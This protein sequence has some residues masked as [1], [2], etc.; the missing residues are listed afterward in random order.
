MKLTVN[1]EP[2]AKESVEREYQRLLKALGPRIEPGELDRISPKLQRQAL[3]HAIGRV[4]LLGEARR[5][6]IRVA[7]EEIDRALAEVIRACGGEA[8]FQTHLAKLNLSPTDLRRQI[9]EA[10]QTERLIEE[11]TKDCPQPEEEEIT[12]YLTE[13]AHEF[14]AEE[15]HPESEPVQ[16]KIRESAH[17]R[18]IAAGKNELLSGFIARLK[19]SAAIKASA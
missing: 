5:R 18:L 11:I 10:R 16:A 9:L 8:G 17:R 7:P 3:D 19:Q 14:L 12:A 15:P 1:G 2:V 4:L 6:E 13:H